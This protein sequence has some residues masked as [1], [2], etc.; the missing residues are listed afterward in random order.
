MGAEEEKIVARQ[1][2]WLLKCQQATSLAK[3]AR[4][5]EHREDY[6]QNIPLSSHFKNQTPGRITRINLFK[7]L[8]NF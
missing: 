4:E 6:V 1:N 3:T 7:E 5:Q 8:P 2:T